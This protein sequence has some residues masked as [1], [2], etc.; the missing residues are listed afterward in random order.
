MVPVLWYWRYL[1]SSTLVLAFPSVNSDFVAEGGA[2]N[3]NQRV[4]HEKSV[5][6]G[7]VPPG[8]VPQ[9]ASP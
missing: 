4:K 1:A 5:V 3:K 7:R 6:H 2:T 8:R 9:A